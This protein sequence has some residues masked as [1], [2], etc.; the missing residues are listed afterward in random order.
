MYK[1]H[2][3]KTQ[4]NIDLFWEW[5]DKYMRED[6]LPNST[7]EPLTPEEEEWFFSQE[8]RDVIME[9]FHRDTATL[10]IV[11]LR[12]NDFNIGFAVYVIYHAENGKCLLVDFNIDAPYRGGGVGAKFFGLLCNHVRTQGAEYIALNLSNEDNQRFWMRNGFALA[13]KDEHGADVYEMRL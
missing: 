2:T 11:F 5:R 12:Q 7:F 4:P 9:A 6:I 8:Y 13:G 1:L 3:V 10:R